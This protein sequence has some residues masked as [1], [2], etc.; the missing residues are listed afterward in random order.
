MRLKQKNTSRFALVFLLVLI[1]FNLLPV[2]VLAQTANDDGF[3]GLVSCGWGSDSGPDECNWQALVAMAQKVVDF[4]LI[5]LMIPLAV[6]A[7]VYA[8]I[9]VI[10][11]K[12]QPA[13]LIKAKGALYNVAI[14]IFLALGA[15]AIIKTILTLLPGGDSGFLKDVITQVFG[16]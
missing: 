11:G 9:Q 3:S 2:L 4:I 7:L 8:G 15:Y 6:I 14:G 5:D 16:S 12:T 1:V 10:R 13:E